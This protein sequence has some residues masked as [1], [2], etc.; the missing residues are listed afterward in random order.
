MRALKLA[1]FEK[2]GGNELA[3]HVIDS[4]LDVGPL[5]KV[6]RNQKSSD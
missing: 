4:L 1:L 2:S 3:D 5:A 6:L